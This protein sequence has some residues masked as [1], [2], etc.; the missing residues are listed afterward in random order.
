MDNGRVK[1]LLIDDD[2][3]SLIITRGMLSEVSGTVIELKGVGTFELGLEAIRRRAFDAYLVDY[4]L[5]SRNGIELIKTAIEEGCRAPL[6]LMTGMGQHDIDKLAMQAGASDFLSKGRVDGVDIERS[7]IHAIKRVEAEEVRLK[8]DTE[9]RMLSQLLPVILW[10]TDE[11]LRFTSGYGAGLQK[12][13][14]ESNQLVGLS[15]VEYFTTPDGGPDLIEPH[16]RALQGESVSYQSRWMGRQYRI[17]DE[18]FDR[19]GR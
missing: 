4:G 14:L 13:G 2:E 5:G 19:L 16:Q 12:L 3:D 9:L 11:R 18:P 1:V 15:L 7:V 6:I 17:Q 8:Q 10:T